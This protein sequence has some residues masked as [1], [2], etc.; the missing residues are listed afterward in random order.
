MQSYYLQWQGRARIRLKVGHLNIFKSLAVLTENALKEINE[1]NNRSDLKRLK[2]VQWSVVKA[3]NC[4]SCTPLYSCMDTKEKSWPP[5]DLSM[6]FKFWEKMLCFCAILNKFIAY[7]ASRSYFSILILNNQ[8]HLFTK[9]TMSKIIL[10]F[11]FLDMMWSCWHFSLNMDTLLFPPS[12]LI[13]TN[14]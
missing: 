14:F 13:I 6:E 7:Y 11:I 2:N 12:R 9:H 8:Y 5:L 1:I 10:H 4:R 3:Q